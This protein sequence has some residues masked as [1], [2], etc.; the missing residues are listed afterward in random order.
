MSGMYQRDTVLR[1]LRQQVMEVHFIKT[2]GEQRSMRCTL[3]RHLLPEMYR[4]N[5][6]EQRE[7]RDFH[8]KNPDVITAWDVEEN[9]WRSFRIN[10][11]FY[12]QA[13]NTSV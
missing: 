10:S 5:Q 11:V 3:Q 8:Q 9:G 13:V 4:T 2:N 1:D 6:E 12:T 7:E